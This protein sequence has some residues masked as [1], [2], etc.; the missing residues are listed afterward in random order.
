MTST[1]ARRLCLLRTCKDGL[2]LMV[3]IFNIRHDLPMCQKSCNSLRWPFRAKNPTLMGFWGVFWGGFWGAPKQ[4]AFGWSRFD[5]E[6]VGVLFGDLL[7][8]F[9]LFGWIAFFL[10]F[11]KNYSTLFH[12]WCGLVSL[13]G[14]SI[15]WWS[16]E[17]LPGWCTRLSEKEPVTIPSHLHS[18]F[19]RRRYLNFDHRNWRSF[20]GVG[21]MIGKFFR[22]KTVKK[23]SHESWSLKRQICFLGVLFQA[24]Q[25]WSP[26]WWYVDP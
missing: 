20:Q 26:S 5:G 10:V 8:R 4:K 19:G 2:M 14:S 24:P 22:G 3:L 11:S 6:N 12:M 15:N 21:L 17:T 23:W 16:S 18:T 9:I 7:L 13:A 25:N 1:I